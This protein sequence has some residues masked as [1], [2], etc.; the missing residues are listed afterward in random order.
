MTMVRV[1]SGSLSVLLGLLLGAGCVPLTRAHLKP[2]TSL[3]QATA[4]AVRAAS[5]AWTIE[6]RLPDPGGAVSW[7]VVPEGQTQVARRA[8]GELAVFAWDVPATRWRDP[9]PFSV[10]IQAAGVDETL[11][12]PHPTSEQRLAKPLSIALEILRPIPHF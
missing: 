6:L 5:G 3:R 11:R 8:E 9:N 12:I 1:R 2:E 10:Q 4:L 7:R